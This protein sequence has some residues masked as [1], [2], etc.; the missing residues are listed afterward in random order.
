M[1]DYFYVYVLRSE[2]DK[3]FSVEFTKDLPSILAAHRKGLVPSTKSR[4]PVELVY[5]EG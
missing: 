4:L 1:R 5:W 2:K 3:N